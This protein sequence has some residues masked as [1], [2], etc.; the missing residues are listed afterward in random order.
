VPKKQQQQQLLLCSK[1]EQ[2]VSP[3]SIKYGAMEISGTNG[4]MEI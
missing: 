1:S 4:N 3:Y 2:E